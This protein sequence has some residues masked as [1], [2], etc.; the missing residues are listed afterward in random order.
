VLTTGVREQMKLLEPQRDSIR[1]S[2]DASIHA[3]LTPE[4]VKLWDELQAKDQARRQRPSDG[5]R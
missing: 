3:L 4:Q 2:A 1:K 5:R